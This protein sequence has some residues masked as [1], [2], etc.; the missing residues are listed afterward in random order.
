MTRIGPNLTVTVVGDVYKLQ[1]LCEKKT[2]FKL[3][4]YQYSKTYLIEEK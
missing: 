1:T 3:S 2:N 4:S